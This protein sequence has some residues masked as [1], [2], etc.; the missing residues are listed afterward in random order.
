MLLIGL[1]ETHFS[2]ILIQIQENAYENVVCK[3]LSIFFHPQCLNSSPPSAAYMHQWIGSV[4]VK[5][6]ACRLFDAKPL[7]EPILEYC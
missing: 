2:E 3:M 5:I 7:P 4:L 6:M 1:L